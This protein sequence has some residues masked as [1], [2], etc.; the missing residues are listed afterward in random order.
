MI[1][2]ISDILK[3]RRQWMLL[4]ASVENQSEYMDIV[5]QNPQKISY[6]P[7]VHNTGGLFLRIGTGSKSL[8]ILS[9]LSCIDALIFLVLCMGSI[10]LTVIE[11]AKTIEILRTNG[12][13]IPHY[14]QIVFIAKTM[15]FILRFL[16]HCVQFIFLFRY[17]N[18]SD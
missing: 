14:P 16:F 2:C 9:Q 3:F 4:T 12:L 10:I 18:V 17:G 1:W 11:L 8:M 6:F 15:T 13:H 7:D 5:E